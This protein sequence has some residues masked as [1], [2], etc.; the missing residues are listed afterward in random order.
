M[1][2]RGPPFSNQGQICLCGSRIFIENSIYDRFVAALVE[3][4]KTLVPADPLLANTRQGALVSRAQYE[5]VL[6]YI[7]LACEEGGRIL[8]GGEPAR[9]EGRCQNGWFVK[10]TLIEGLDNT[11]RTIKRKFSDRWRRCS[12]FPRKMKFCKKANDVRYGLSASVFTS[13]LSRA[14]RMARDIHSGIVWVNTWMMRD[15]RTPFGGV[16]DSGMGREGGMEALRFLPNPKPCACV[17]KRSLRRDVYENSFGNGTGTRRR[18]SSCATC[19]QFVI[20]VRR[21]PA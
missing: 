1:K 9:V 16:K 19:G 4:T 20:H 5:K 10:P 2:W 17:F 21:G 15:L 6:G 3:R 11:C 13:D 14:H 12:R 18:V 7:A 8:C